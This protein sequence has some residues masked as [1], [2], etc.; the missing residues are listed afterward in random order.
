M[1]A[2]KLCQILNIST[3]MKKAPK[4]AVELDSYK[5]RLWFPPPPR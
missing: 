3:Q 4:P 5:L 1:S 2:G